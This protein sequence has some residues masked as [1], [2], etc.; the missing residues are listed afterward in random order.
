M[1]LLTVAWSM[2][3]AASVVLGGLH[4]V[5]WLKDRQ[6]WIY[7]LSA[8]MAFAAGATALTHLGLMR[9]GSQ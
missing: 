7:L 4:G 9:A 1:S 2:V 6:R 8:L 3:A 5:L